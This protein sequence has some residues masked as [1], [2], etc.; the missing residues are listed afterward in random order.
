MF[1]LSVA[2][3]LTTLVVAPAAARAD[4]IVQRAPGAS[5]AAVRTDAG[6]QLVDTL[7][8]ARTQVVKADPGQSQADA[9]AALKADPDV[10]YAEPDRS[11]HA[12]TSDTYWS[13]QPD[14]PLISAPQAWSLSTGAGV[15]VAVVDTG[16]ELTHEDLAG[17]FAPGGHDFVDGDDD[18]TDENGHGTHVSGTIAALADNGTG[19]AGIAPGAKLMEL[20]AL[21]ANGSGTMSDVA[22][23]FD[24]A[25]RQGVPVVNASLGGGY[26]QAVEDAIAAHP[27]TLYV[28]AAGN[29]GADDDDPS[30]AEYPCAYPL[31]NIVCV[32]ATNN[33]DQ[34]ASFSNYGAT[35]VDLYAPGVNIVSTYDSS[36][37]GYAY[38]SGTSMATPHVAG[39]AALVVAADPGVSAAQVKR[40]LLSTVDPVAALSGL[41]VSGG[42]LNADAAVAS[43]LGVTPEPA[44]TP[45]PTPAPTST[46]AP[47]PVSTPAPAPVSTPA[48]VAPAPARTVAPAPVLRHLHLR[49]SLGTPHGRL[50]VTF[51]LTRAATVRFTVARTGSRSSAG[52]WTIRAQA[53]A[54]AL[55]LTRRLPTHRTL[56][57]G[58]YTLRVG[59]AATASTARFSV[60]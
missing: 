60:R 43:I 51:S 56:A 11:M 49:G 44:P 46:P 59:L 37:S 17:Q 45:T 52:S 38:M 32:G 5:A 34:P 23:A 27:N 29:D 3:A 7:P 39:A 14:L 20:R 58:S 24:Y 33:Q 54:N 18:P 4:I 28:V 13:L 6:V 8:L 9:L 50:R 19:V 40:A 36:P 25:G 35:S 31:A 48:P 21:D 2:L 22:A 53:G 26:S 12:L 15:T 42:R 47:A 1:R 55:T 41:S 16:A 57:P 10:V 30:S